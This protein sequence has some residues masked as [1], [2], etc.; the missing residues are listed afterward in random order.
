[1]IWGPTIQTC[2][3]N[4]DFCDTICQLLI[5]STW[6]HDYEKQQF[7]RHSFRNINDVLTTLTTTMLNGKN[8]EKSKFCQI[9]MKKLKRSKFLIDAENKKSESPILLK[10]DEN[11][12]QRWCWFD[13]VI[14]WKT[15]W[16]V[17]TNLMRAERLVSNVDSNVKLQNLVASGVIR[18]PTTATCSPLCGPRYA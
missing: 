13:A 10:I 12:E 7:E 1:M 5:T 8:I 4:N 2:L 15:N 18:V 17:P 3:N 14:I 6:L 11:F 16:Q 9:I